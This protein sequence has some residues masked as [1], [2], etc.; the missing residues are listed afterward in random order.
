MTAQLAAN[1]TARTGWADLEPGPLLRATITAVGLG[2]TS[3][4]L[5]AMTRAAAGLAAAG[6]GAKP[7]AVLFHLAAVVP[8]V[9]LGAWLLL[10]RKGTARHKLLG[11]VWLVLM[12]AAA[13]SA[14]FIRQLNNGSF[15]PIHVFVPLTLW[16]AWNAIRNARA[17]DIAKHRHG[18]IRLYLGALTIPGILSFIPGRLMW[19]W[20][21]G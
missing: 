13:L 8:C 18:L 7:M 5:I 19:T 21:V 11:K 9:P 14:V 15:S 6:S 3:A 17:G 1:R 4:C 20:L 16:G 2:F 12:V 10:K